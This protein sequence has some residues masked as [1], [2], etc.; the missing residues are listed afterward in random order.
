MNGINMITAS[1]IAVIDPQEKRVLVEGPRYAMENISAAV[2]GGPFIFVSG[3]RGTVDPKTG[4]RVSEEMP[5]SFS[6]QT[7]V[8]YEVIESILKDCG[9][10]A[11]SVLR[12]DCYI[13]DGSRASEETVV[14]DEILGTSPRAATRVALP[15]SA[16]GEVEIT[17]LAAAP[18]VAKR[19]LRGGIDDPV[20]VAAGGFLFVGECLGLGFERTQD[21]A[22]LI[23]DVSSQVEHAMQSLEVSLSRANTSLSNIVRLEV[24][25]RDIYQAQHVA[26]KLA[27]LIGD[28]L[29]SI[30]IAGAE[31]EDSLEVKLNAIAVTTT[32]NR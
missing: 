8:C 1:V 2:R 31:L 11:D 13:R 6:A 15:L 30:V 14:R 5:D 32:V 21:R 16:R 7:K 24:Y 19:S 4:S 27:R 17:T 20:V 22:Q 12:L 29:P 10:S 9:L 3:I 26:A 18:G 28:D 25:L 23:G